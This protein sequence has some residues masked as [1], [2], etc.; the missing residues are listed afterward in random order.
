M[1]DTSVVEELLKEHIYGGFSV[2]YT[3]NAL[4]IWRSETYY[5]SLYDKE[6]KN[7]VQ[8]EHQ[9]FFYR[10]ILQQSDNLNNVFLAGM[11]FG[12]LVESGGLNVKRR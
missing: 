10:I 6:T 8:D 5:Q 3:G 9:P 1:V 11:L 4:T 12:G 2:S 7:I